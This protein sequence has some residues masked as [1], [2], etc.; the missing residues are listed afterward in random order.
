MAIIGTVSLAGAAAVGVACAGAAG[1]GVACAAE[2]GAEVGTG[3]KAGVG[4]GGTGVEVGS[5]LIGS[6][7]GEGGAAGV[8]G[9]G[10]QPTAT[11]RSTQS[12][13]NGSRF[14]SSV[15]LLYWFAGSCPVC[16]E[17]RPASGYS[18]HYAS[19]KAVGRNL[20]L[21][22]ASG[23][24]PDPARPRGRSRSPPQLGR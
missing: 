18:A 20:H 10:A 11:A 7:V 14:I 8:A 22:H 23:P 12:K 1:V 24:R 6:G 21:G 4:G 5:T 15:L 16:G 9:E 17:C 13:N 3:V 19:V 2:V